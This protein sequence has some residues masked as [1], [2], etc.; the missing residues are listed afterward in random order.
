MDFLNQLMNGLTAGSIYALIAI[1]YTMVYGI[2][3]MLNF[4]HGDVVMIGAYI[5]WFVASQLGLPLPLAILISVIGCA[6]LGI[7]MEKIAYKPLR[8]AKPLSVLITAIGV[9]FFL[10][11]M[12][13]LLFSSTKQTFPLDLGVVPN[14]TLG[15]LVIPGATIIILLVASVCMTLLYLFVTKTKAG[16]AMLAVSEDKD[17]ARLMGIDVDR[18]I[19]LTFAVGS[20]LA[21]VSGALFSG[22]YFYVYP[23]M[24]SMVGIKAF[25]AAVIGGIGSI[26]G[27]ML[28]GILLGIIESLSKGYISTAMSNAFV[29]GAL[30]IVLLVKPTGLLGKKTIEK[31]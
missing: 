22:Y 15:K 6:I 12:A 13:L 31:V 9:S 30:I 23:T 1:G 8:N 5:I 27:A 29:F 18:T 25:V 20:I 24:G 10:Q 4:A 28:G 17:A 16:S 19:S 26:P 14:I 7:S 11:A 2:A 21:S 3:K